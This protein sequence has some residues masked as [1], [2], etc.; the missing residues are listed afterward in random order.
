MK[1]LSIEEILK[2]KKLRN[3]IVWGNYDSKRNNRRY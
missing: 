2:I 3:L 1:Y